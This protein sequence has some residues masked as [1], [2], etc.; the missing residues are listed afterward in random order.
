V[1]SEVLS[2]AKNLGKASGEGAVGSEATDR[3]T[4]AARDLERSERSRRDERR[5]AGAVSSENLGKASGERSDPRAAGSAIRSDRSE[6]LFPTVGN[7]GAANS[8]GESGA[9]NRETRAV[10][11]V[12]RELRDRDRGAGERRGARGGVGPHSCGSAMTDIERREEWGYRPG[13]HGAAAA[14]G[15][16]GYRLRTDGVSVTCR[17]P[18]R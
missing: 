5:P 12:T 8:E 6:Y 3:E 11:G 4:R 14:R 13:G 9:R 10:N 2:G 16:T 17:S 7:T 15:V 1:S 18:R